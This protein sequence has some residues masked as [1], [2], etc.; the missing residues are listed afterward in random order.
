MDGVRDVVL[1]KDAI[2][3]MM[4]KGR[5]L[6][7][8]LTPTDIM[9]LSGDYVAGDAEASRIGLE[10]LAAKMG[11]E[12]NDLA[13]MILERVITRIGEEIVKKALADSIGLPPGSRATDLLMHALGGENIVPRVELHVSIDRP[14]VGIGAPAGLLV[15]PLA[16][17]MDAKVLV[18]EN[19]DVGNAVGAVCSEMTESITLEISPRENKFLVYSQYSTPMEFYHLEEAVSSA[20]SSAERHVVG[21]LEAARAKD[22]KVKIDR[23]E[24]RFSDGYGK[25]M[26][27]VSGILIRAIAT[28]KPDLER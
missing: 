17:R 21:K 10:L 5:L 25:E 19:H 7:T 14:V 12:P 8:G 2:T 18:P 4:S 20:R 13:D 16:D 3:A 26:K 9:H 27:F 6:R 28:G 22:I 23:I 24:N 1:I 11:A 15:A